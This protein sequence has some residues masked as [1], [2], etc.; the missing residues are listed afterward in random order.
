MHGLL[1]CDWRDA[2][3]ARVL[4]S[5]VIIWSQN[6]LHESLQTGRTRSMVLNA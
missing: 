2:D 6:C 3:G 4:G 1:R 5:W